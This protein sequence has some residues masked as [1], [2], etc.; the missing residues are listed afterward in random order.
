MNHILKTWLRGAAAG[1]IGL[2]LGGTAYAQ[3]NAPVGKDAYPPFGSCSTSQIPDLGEGWTANTLLTPFQSQPLQA[4]QV[5]SVSTVGSTRDPAMLVVT[6]TIPST[7]QVGWY[8]HGDVTYKLINGADGNLQCSKVPNS[9]LWVAPVANFLGGKNCNCMGSNKVAGV[10]S[11]AWRCPNGT[12]GEYDWFWFDKQTHAPK[13]FLFSRANNQQQLPVLGNSSLVH[14]T[15]YSTNDGLPIGLAFNA[16]I[17]KNVPPT[18]PLP[19]PAVAG[20][21]FESESS[22]RPEPP[23]WPDKAFANGA[24]FAVDGSYTGMAIYYDWSNLQEVSKILSPNEKLERNPKSSLLHD[25]RL[26]K[27][28]TYQVS[29]DELGNPVFPTT[30]KESLAGGIMGNVGIW[31]P[32]WAR[33]D[34]CQYKAT[35]APGT[36]LNPNKDA[37]PI[38]AMSCFFAQGINGVE[39]NIQAWYTYDQKPVMFYESNARDLD[40]IDYYKWIPDAHIDKNVFYPVPNQTKNLSPQMMTECNACH[41]KIND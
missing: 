10:E 3:Q 28:R 32:D 15:D 1:L 12:K 35:I 31:R 2:G 29:H 24:L 20:V 21:T 7:N 4:A 37:A 23:V 40:M 19:K 14:F 38:Q 17:A 41:G 39:S 27:G 9:N 5:T 13:R 30:E 8:V 26:T 36:P 22:K 33:N 6:D 18:R 16:C 34:S 11:D 25:T